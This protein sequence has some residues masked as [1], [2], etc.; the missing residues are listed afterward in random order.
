MISVIMP[1]YNGEHHLKEAIDSILNQ[2]YSDFE[3]LIINDGSSDRSEEIILSYKDDR[4]KYIINETNLG[5]VRTLNK[6]IDL[7]SSKYIIRMDA[8]DIS[9]PHRFEKQ[10]AFMEGHPE[11][12]ASGTNILKFYNDDINQIKSSNVKLEDRDLKIRT[13]FYTAFWHPTMIMKT[14]VLKDN[15]LRYRSDYKYAQDKAL[16]IDISKHGAI[17]NQN[18]PLLY[19]RVHENQVSKKFFKEQYAI[20]M[21]ITREALQNLGIPMSKY[22]D[23]IVGYIA[24]PQRCM[25]IADLYQ[26][27][28]FS[29]DIIRILG[30]N[31]DFDTDAIKTFING[32]ITKTLFK[33]LNI[34]VS[35]IYFIHK[36]KYVDLKDFDYRFFIKAFLKRNTRS[37]Q[38]AG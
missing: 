35:L 24:Y 36:S 37:I 8:D 20:S 28:L 23:S 17:A 29:D 18:E 1:V 26:V 5:I 9:M 7:A 13:I 21:G 12:A 38:I 25:D 22:S 15:E 10:I 34:G 27:E 4:I 19:Y 16:W 31:P 11:I 30:A 32:Q 33:S 3:F 6:G 2:S 14:Q